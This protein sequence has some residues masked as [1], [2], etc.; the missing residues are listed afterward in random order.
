M[1]RLQNLHA[2]LDIYEKS[3]AKMDYCY[4]EK[5]VLMNFF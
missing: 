3:P 1:K 4:I 5:H 2:I